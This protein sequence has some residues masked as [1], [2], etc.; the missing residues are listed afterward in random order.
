MT[1]SAQKIA[2]I[3]SFHLARR[4]FIVFD[5]GAVLV[6]PERCALSHKDWLLE[7]Y[8]DECTVRRLIADC[9]RGYIL[10]NELRAYTGDFCVP[11]DLS[12]VELAYS[13][14]K[15]KFNICR[16]TLGAIKNSM[17]QPWPPITVLR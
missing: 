6:A 5:N 8:D 4:M 7:L 16:V 14:L 10:D 9:V 2:D 17:A 13:A 12:H 3:L 1:T 11:Q 15:T